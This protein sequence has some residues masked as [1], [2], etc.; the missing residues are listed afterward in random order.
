MI[1]VE[2]TCHVCGA[3]VPAARVE[4][5]EG[6]NVPENLYTCVQHAPTERKCGVYRQPG[7]LGEGEFDLSDLVVVAPRAEDDVPWLAPVEADD[8]ND[9]DGD[10]ELSREEVAI[11]LQTA[12]VN[13]A[14]GKPSTPKEPKPPRPPKATGR[15]AFR[16]GDAEVNAARILEFIKDQPLSSG[17]WAAL[18]GKGR[19]T[20]ELWLKILKDSG[21]VHKVGKLWHVTVEII[22]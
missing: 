3:P 22:P 18:A 4:F 19:S 12:R 10:L 16:P 5:L 20:F 17:D 14:E 11:R 9:D 7:D 15:K 2:S 1:A 6:S 8:E 13:G 21:R